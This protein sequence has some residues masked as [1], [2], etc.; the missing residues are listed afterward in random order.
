MRFWSTRLVCLWPAPAHFR[1]RLVWFTFGW[2]GFTVQ[3]GL[4]YFGEGLAHFE[5]AVW[6]TFWEGLIYFSARSGLLWEGS[7]LRLKKGLAYLLVFFEPG[8]AYSR[9]GLVYFGEG[10]ACFEQGVWFTFREGLV[11]FSGRS[12]LLLRVCRLRLKK[13]LVHPFGCCLW[14]GRAH[15]RERLV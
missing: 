11:Y 10:L 8:P 7:G 5:E 1:G 3:Q 14:P 4:A 2:S 6:F 9:E 13:G 15:S 12:G